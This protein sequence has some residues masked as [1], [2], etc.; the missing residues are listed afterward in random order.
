MKK[1][2]SVLLA[3]L[4]LTMSMGVYASEPTVY[5]EGNLKYTLTSGS[6]TIVGSYGTA[7]EITIPNNIAGYPVNTIKAGALDGISGL[8]T[9]H[10]PS[11]VTSLEK[12]AIPD[13]VTKV[14]LPEDGTEYVAKNTTTGKEYYTVKDALDEA[15]ENQVINLLDNTGCGEILK[16][17]TGKKLNLNGHN[18]TVE[19]LYITGQLYDS[20]STKGKVTAEDYM[21]SGEQVYSPIYNPANGTVSF[22]NLVFNTNTGFGMAENSNKLYF[23]L[24]GSKG[25]RTPAVE[26][27]TSDYDAE[28][29]PKGYLKRIKAVVAVSWVDSEGISLKKTFT[30]PD[31]VMK[32]MIEWYQNPVGNTKAY[33][34]SISGIAGKAV[35][36][37]AFEFYDNDGN[38]LF[39]FKWLEFT[40]ETGT[41]WTVKSAN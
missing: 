8:T 36:Q 33:T 22:F 38:L 5:T 17:K 19:T 32:T 20:A 35:M 29:N 21:I 4:V 30:F 2:I 6:I 37:P 25:E 41:N 40:T 39:T 11:S 24:F 34:I 31:T 15:Q 14:D 10:I 1:V 28:T 26:L 27:L 16:V 23:G 3:L 12:G 7:S 9:V 18:L 13:G